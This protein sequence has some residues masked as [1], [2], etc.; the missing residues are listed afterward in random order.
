MPCAAL[1]M[2]IRKLD[3]L[4]SARSVARERR[5][6]AEFRWDGPTCGDGHAPSR[7]GHGPARAR[8]FARLRSRAES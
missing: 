4:A 5:G 1:R 7:R 6:L 2:V 3:E 8:G